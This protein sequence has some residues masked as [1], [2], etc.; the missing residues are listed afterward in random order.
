M[1]GVKQ[2]VSQLA[3]TVVEHGHGLGDKR[4]PRVGKADDGTDCHGQP[5]WQVIAVYQKFCQAPK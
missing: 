1:H 3:Q 5:R 4:Q 2:I